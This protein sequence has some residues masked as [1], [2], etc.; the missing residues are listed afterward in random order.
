L[1]RGAAKLSAI[2]LAT[3][4]RKLLVAKIGFTT[5]SMSARRIY[6]AADHSPIIS[7]NNSSII[8]QSVYYSKITRVC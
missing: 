2:S 5:G 6:F 1:A 8:D 4:R 7:T 3:T